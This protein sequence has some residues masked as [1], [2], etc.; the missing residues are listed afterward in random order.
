[1][2]VAALPGDVLDRAREISARPWEIYLTGTMRIVGPCGA[3]ALPRPRK[4]RALLAFLCL[5]PPKRHS[6]TRLVSL[7]WEKPDR[8]ARRNLRDALYKL[9]RANGAIAAGLIQADNE[10]VWLNRDACWID[11]YSSPFPAEQLLEDLDGV[12]EEFDRWLREQRDSFENRVRQTLE[13]E[14]DALIKDKAS[15]KLRAAAARNL[16][17]FDEKHEDGLYAL[18]LALVDLG[19]HAQALRE[20]DRFRADLFD[21]LKISPSRK[22]ESLYQAIRI[23]S[24]RNT[25]QVTPI[26][27][28]GLIAG[29]Q[30]SNSA[31]PPPPEPS[32]AVLPFD[33]LIAGQKYKYVAEGLAE[34]LIRSLSSLPGFFVTSR[35]TTRTF[36]NKRRLPR[37][38]GDLL[39]VRYILSGSMRLSGAR[40]YL[41]AEL[42]DA[43]KGVV[44][45]SWS[46]ETRITDLLNVQLDLAA[47]I[48]REAAPRLRHA[49]LRRVCVASPDQ[50]DAYGF[51]LRAQE[52]MHN[53]SQASFV[54]A[55]R[56][57]HEA[58]R[59][60]PDY[61]KALAWLAYWHVLRVGQ[62]WSL[63]PTRDAQLAAE[64][65][66]R[67]A[68]SDESEPMAFAVQ[69]HIAT[70][71]HKDFDLGFRYFDQ[72][73]RA[74]PNS[75]PAWLWSAAASAWAGDGSRAITE[76]DKAT[77]LSP[78]DPLLY[79]HNS[80][81]SVAHLAAGENERAVELALRAIRENPGYTAAYKQL[82]IALV[83]SGRGAEARGPVQ[84]LL[85]LEPSFSVETYR[86]RNP[87]I[88]TRVEQ[89]YK[90]LK[91]AGVPL[92]A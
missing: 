79:A 68:D 54:E 27:S 2:T 75:A 9:E 6:R 63:D 28:S 70:Y 5:E 53:A 26:R 84:R 55:E 58:L 12:S 88:T 31:T 77:A 3:D 74:N 37:D 72:A 11:V 76:A 49:E 43:V 51:F 47:E 23:S 60:R 64:F 83:M 67:A 15:A 17:N 36:R 25:V 46:T 42:A 44:L 13:A 40:L 45:H 61:A 56:L 48:V 69:G 52:A 85:K 86:R 82:V 80:V 14:L 38:I 59:C 21:E 16:V 39:E 29:N 18:M 65:A 10:Y 73:R 87:H 4:I 7:L 32:I 91:T 81:A 62:G 90:A 50:V 57:F 35:Q 1:V 71:L 34:D 22:I 66:R 41:T 92:H 24:P 33:N 8:S 89:Y 20:Y 78:Y 30:N 19:Q